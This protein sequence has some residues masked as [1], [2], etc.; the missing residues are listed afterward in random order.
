MKNGE[1]KGLDQ[2]QYRIVNAS[3]MRFPTHL[4]RAYEVLRVT[5]GSAHTLIDGE[6]RVLCEG[7]CAVVF[8]L[9][10]HSFA[11]EAD[12]RIRI[13]I[14][15][16]ELIPEFSARMHGKIPEDPILPLP[17]ELFPTQNPA[18]IFE[19]K[20]FFYRLCGALS[21][22]LVLREET[23]RRPLTAI[24]NIFLYV[25]R[26]FAS[27]CSLKTVS[28]RLRYDYSY[29]SKGFKEQTGISYNSYVNR[30]R[31]SRA[32]YLL[33]AVGTTVTEAAAAVGFNSIR[34]FNRV[35]RK[36]I[37]VTPREYIKTVSAQD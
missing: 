32:C 26:N 23:S 13:F 14:F 11:V 36:H 9:Q 7:E 5:H 20:A 4:H 22:R 30:I 15:S 19:A 6:E 34:T 21:A 31:V 33:I 12:S 27:D 1:P 37:G 17:Q 8:P 10:H 35:F 25:D 28:K 2:K 3:D 29:L 24:D 18:E 16:P